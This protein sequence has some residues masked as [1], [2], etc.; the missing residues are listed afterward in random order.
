MCDIFLRLQVRAFRKNQRGPD[1]QS[2][3]R[4]LI[5]QGLLAGGADGVFG[6]L[7]DAATRAFQQREGLVVDGVAGAQTLGRAQAL[8]FEL[9]RRLRD[10]DVTPALTLEA[11]RLLALHR[12]EPYGSE[13]PFDVEG[14]RYV[15]RLEQHYHE[16]GGPLR[17][18]GYHPGISL[19]IL[20]VTLGPAELVYDD[21]DAD[22][23]A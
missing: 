15:A 5:G 4:F 16:P 18:W 2:W 23:P 1:I 6:N 7:T 11:K 19:F 10:A 20:V 17:P 12:H 14:C 22:E 21:A 9:L 3:Q 8:G 13:Y